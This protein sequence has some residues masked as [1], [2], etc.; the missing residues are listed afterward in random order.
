MRAQERPRAE[1][2]PF[3]GGFLP[4]NPDLFREAYL[5]GLGG[6][7]ELTPQ[8]TAVGTF[9]WTAGTLVRTVSTYNV[10]TFMYDAGVERAFHLPERPTSDWD[11]GPFAGAGVGGHTY[12]YKDPAF[13]TRSFVSGYVSLGDE[14]ILGRLSLRIEGRL[15]GTQ[16]TGPTPTSTSS[17]RTDVVI[18]TGLAWHLR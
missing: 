5:V 12:A 8:I 2:R 9:G 17:L 7:V 16:F 13:A 1:L 4:T 6:G 3:V 18:F 14:M 15:Y 11:E 10:N